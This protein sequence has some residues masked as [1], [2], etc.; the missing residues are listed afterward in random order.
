[1]IF[2]D[3]FSHDEPGVFGPIRDMLLGHGDYY[4]HLAD[5][6]AY[7]RAQ[8][9][10]GSLY[11]DSDAWTCKAIMNVGCSGKFST[12]RTIAEYAGDTWKVKAVRVD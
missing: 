2:S 10:V 1:L 3:H 11:S 12:D 5:L 8:S 4:M 6:T 7:A 9:E